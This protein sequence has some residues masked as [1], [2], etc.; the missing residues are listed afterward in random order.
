MSRKYLVLSGL[1]LITLIIIIISI[2]GGNE[3]GKTEPETILPT[4]EIQEE[5]EKLQEEYFIDFDINLEGRKITLDGNT[6]LPNESQL[7]VGI[8]RYVE[9]FDE[10]LQEPLLGKRVVDFDNSKVQ[11]QDGKFSYSIYLTDREWYKND[12]AENKIIGLILT[13]IYN[14][15][16][17]SIT[18][19]PARNLQPERVYKILGNKF[20]KMKG[21]QVEES[22]SVGN[23][24]QLHKEFNLSIE[25]GA[26]VQ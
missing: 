3:E 6:N 5:L 20:E 24:I 12:L 7:S 19:T 2:G 8:H 21:N 22:G 25:E 18:F 4:Q 11:V 23:V 26:V 14:D 10:G 1:L 13:K 16:Y 17:A 15:C 9:Y